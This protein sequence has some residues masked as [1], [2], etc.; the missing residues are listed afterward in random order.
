M[1]M[2]DGYSASKQIKELI[3]KEQYVDLKIIS[4][5]CN[6]IDFKE[7]KYKEAKFDGNLLKPAT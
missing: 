2:M 6:D 3:E 5:S 1:P 4:Y 7:L